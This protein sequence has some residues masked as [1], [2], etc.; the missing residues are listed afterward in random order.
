MDKIKLV[1]LLLLTVAIRHIHCLSIGFYAKRCPRAENIISRLV[2]LAS[3]RDPSL[4]AALLR[5]HYHDCFVGGCDASVLLDSA[6]GY[7][8]P[9]KIASPNQSLRGYEVVDLIKRVLESVCPLTVSCADILAL[10]ARDA[11]ASAGGP[12]WKIPTG[13]RDSRLSSA[14]I[15][16]ISMPRPL[17][18]QAEL[19]STFFHHGLSED[20]LITLSGA[21]T[22][23]LAHCKSIWDRLYNFGSGK[24]TDPSMNRNYAALL[25]MICPRNNRNSRMVVPLDPV[26][27]FKFDNTYYKNL[28]KGFGLLASDQIIIH[29]KMASEFGRNATLWRDRFRKAMIHL[30][31]LNVK[32]NNRGEIRRNCRRRN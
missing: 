4:P 15:A 30:S 25:K 32:E 8:P 31:I 18:S 17:S 6:Y 9:E 27:P 3:R 26:S 23:G 24:L 20:E 14:L 11:V 29:N 22:I 2:W 10:S 19:K 28:E 7:P 16:E 21:H 5:L 1:L 13:R 12:H